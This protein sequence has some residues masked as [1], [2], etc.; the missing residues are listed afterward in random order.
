MRRMLSANQPLL[1]LTQAAQAS[2][3]A[4]A[5]KTPGFELSFIDLLGSSLKLAAA[6][7]ERGV[8]SRDVV[9]VNADW[10]FQALLTL[11][12]WAIRARGYALPSQRAW[13]TMPPP[14][15]LLTQTEHEL[16]DRYPSIRVDQAFVDQALERTEPFELS[17]F[18]EQ[19]ICRYLFSSGTTG[20]P[21][22][23]PIT[24]ELLECR[25]TLIHDHWMPAL[26]FFS[27]LPVTAGHGL[28]AL[29]NALATGTTYYS[30][31]S[32]EENLTIIQQESIGSIIGS[33]AQLEALC[34][35]SEAATQRLGDLDT[36]FVTGSALTAEL[37]QR[38]SKVSKARVLSLYGATE[39]GPVATGELDEHG[40]LQFEAPRDHV[41]VKRRQDGA[42]DDDTGE[43]LIIATTNMVDGV[44]G[45]VDEAGHA[46]FST[47]D[48]VRFSADGS[49][50]L[51]G[52]TNEV[53][54]VGGVKV[55]LSEL[56][57]EVRLFDEVSDAA[58]VEYEPSR[59]VLSV[60]MED[61]GAAAGVLERARRAGFG[62]PLDAV[63]VLDEL[64]VTEFGKLQREA[65]AEIYRD[66]V[67]Q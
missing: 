4:L 19:E 22:A 57:N 1:H 33:V 31:G 39:V 10:G 34:A 36:I 56:E 3:R 12:L 66:Q 58:I 2:P 46:W 15:M 14:T 55:N 28:Y 13:A 59:Y 45:I 17:V 60:V 24:V 43:A 25:S 62:I 42:M 41:S 63:L 9:A 67:A 23:L 5:L 48:L 16:E 54:N 7:Q 26:P 50:E 8:V 37:A 6:L 20:A 52:R 29:T 61:H 49:F 35:A 51:I 30:P 11:A 53:A 47:G 27:L 32:P 21:V 64:P 38:I 40:T 65:I 18:G 44:G